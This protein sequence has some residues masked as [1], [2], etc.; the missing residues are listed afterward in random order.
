[1][2]IPANRYRDPEAALALI[3]GVPG[4]EEQAVYRD[5]NG[6]SRYTQIR[7]GAGITRF[8]PG[9]E[10]RD[11]DRHMADPAEI[12]NRETT[13]IHAVLPDARRRE[14]RRAQ[15][16]AGRARV[17]LRLT[18]QDYRGARCTTADPEG[19]IR[20]FGGCDPRS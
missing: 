18:A 1:M 15:V 20:C 8:G 9:T 19:H 2:R 6:A 14:E 10:G 3:T 4:L 5:D 7:P 17:P 13:T 16:R 12:G 11:P